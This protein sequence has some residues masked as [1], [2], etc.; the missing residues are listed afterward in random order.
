MTIPD[1]ACGGG[2]CR[3]GLLPRMSHSLNSLS[4][5]FRV[6]GLNSLKRVYI[7]PNDGESN[8][9]EKKWTIKW[10]LL[11]TA[12]TYIYIYRAIYGLYEP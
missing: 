1:Q 11:Y 5:G 2:P 12:S 10:K 3:L 4:I 7:Y 8:G 6:Y 9:M